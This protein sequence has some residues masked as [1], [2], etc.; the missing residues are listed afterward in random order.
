MMSMSLFSPFM[1]EILT[2]RGGQTR[3]E[4]MFRRVDNKRIG[5]G[6][7]H[8]KTKFSAQGRVICSRGTKGRG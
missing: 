8:P 6:T 1:F 2:I 4:S 7:R 5:I 3:Q